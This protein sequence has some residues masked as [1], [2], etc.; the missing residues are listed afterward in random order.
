MFHI[1][2]PPASRARDR[3]TLKSY[4]FAAFGSGAGQSE[5]LPGIRFR[6]FVESCSV[7]ARF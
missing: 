1:A 6:D 2:L 7:H 5:A 4:L 3:P